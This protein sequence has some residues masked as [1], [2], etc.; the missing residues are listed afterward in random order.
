MLRS[1]TFSA[2][3]VALVLG[4]LPLAPGGAQGSTDDGALQAAR[5]ALVLASFEG[6]QLTVGQLEDGIQNKLPRTRR[7]LATPEGRLGFLREA[8]DYELLILEAQARGYAGHPEVRGAAM[9]EAI[10]TM[11]G[12]PADPDELRRIEATKREAAQKLLA[13]VKVER[14]PGSLPLIVLDRPRHSGPAGHN[15][16]PTDPLAAPKIVVPEDG[17]GS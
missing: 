15:I 17:E 3:V 7:R 11:F 1:C 6:G 5:R 9:E 10:D 16:L 8:V 2:L 13:G 12:R 4:P 14:S